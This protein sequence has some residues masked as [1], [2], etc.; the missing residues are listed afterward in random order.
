MQECGSSY[1]YEGSKPIRVKPVTQALLSAL[2][3]QNYKDVGNS[4]GGE[5]RGAR[6]GLQGWTPG[7]KVAMASC[8]VKGR[9]HHEDFSITLI[10]LL[11]DF[12]LQR[13]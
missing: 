9:I 5:V 3:A 10:Y 12:F 2:N 4:R 1:F 7:K 13:L 6:K 11:A 8:S